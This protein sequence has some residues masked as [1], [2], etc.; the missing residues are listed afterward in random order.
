MAFKCSFWWGVS[1]GLLASLV[2]FLAPFASKS[3]GEACTRVF[4]W[5]G[6]NPREQGALCLAVLLAVTFTIGFIAGRGLWILV[7]RLSDS[8]GSST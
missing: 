3:L 1:G 2:G 5:L 4:V 8:K 6:L 7:R